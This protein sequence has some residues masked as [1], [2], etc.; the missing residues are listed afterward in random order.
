LD[1]TVEFLSELASLYNNVHSSV[2]KHAYS[3][4]LVELLLPVAAV[5]SMYIFEYD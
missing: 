3:N 4:V 5:I 2:L 1:E